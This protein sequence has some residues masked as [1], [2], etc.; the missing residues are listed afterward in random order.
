LT[1]SFNSL[2]NAARLCDYYNCLDLVRPWFDHWL[3]D[4]VAE[5]KRPGQ[6]EWLLIAWAFG[7]VDIFKNLASKMVLEVMTNDKQECLTLQGKIFAI[8]LPH[9]IVRGLPL[10]PLNLNSQNGRLY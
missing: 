9:G 4:S 3:K 10:A 1:L 6:E 2:L 5:S 8:S 7:K